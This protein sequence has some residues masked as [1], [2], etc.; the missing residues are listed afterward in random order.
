MDGGGS[1]GGV[2]DEAEIWDSHSE[3]SLSINL[4]SLVCG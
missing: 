1:S 3:V 4:V 2:G